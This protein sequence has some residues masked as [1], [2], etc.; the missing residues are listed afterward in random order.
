[1]HLGHPGH[2][3]LPALSAHGGCK[4]QCESP[5]VGQPGQAFLSHTAR[6][7]GDAPIFKVQVD[8][9]RPGIQVPDPVNTAVPKAVE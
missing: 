3:Q 2:G 8:A 1:M 9:G 7:A 6:R 4:A 5:R